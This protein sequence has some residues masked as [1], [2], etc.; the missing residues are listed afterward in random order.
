MNTDAVDEMPKCIQQCV[1]S[2][3]ADYDMEREKRREEMTYNGSV[4]KGSGLSCRVEEGNTNKIQQEIYNHGPVAAHMFICDDLEQ[5]D[6][7]SN[8]FI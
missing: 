8:L 7:S 3:N 1:P 6:F 4:D 5:H 2:Y